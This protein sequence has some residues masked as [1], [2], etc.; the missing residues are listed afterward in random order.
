MQLSNQVPDFK[1]QDFK[2]A[3]MQDPHLNDEEKLQVN[4]V[5]EDKD[6]KR[7]ILY[8]FYGAGLA[9][10]ISRYLSLT[11]PSQILLSAAGFGLGRLLVDSTGE[12]KND[13]ARYNTKLRQ[14][15]IN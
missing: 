13:F 5:L 8:G 2:L 10:L 3:V 1:W 7:K 14:Y 11:P 12:P 15:E 6:A 4:T 9:Y